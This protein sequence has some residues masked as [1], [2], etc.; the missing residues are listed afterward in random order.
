[1]T[2]GSIRMEF[3]KLHHFLRKEKESRIAA[4]NEEENEKGAKMER[5]IQ[6]GIVSL[7]DRIRE[8]E[9]RMEDDD[10]TFLKVGSDTYGCDAGIFHVDGYD[11]YTPIL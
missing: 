8:V 7:S 1:M 9:E 10:I 11:T 5:A 2:E 6:E 4:L 3:D